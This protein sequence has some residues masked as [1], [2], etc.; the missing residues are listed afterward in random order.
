MRWAAVVTL[1]APTVLFAGGPAPTPTP[2][3]RPFRVQTMTP[4]PTAPTPTPTTEPTDARELEEQA[5]ILLEIH[6]KL[7]R[8]G[9]EIEKLPTKR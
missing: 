4:V 3:L 5:R 8:L 9:A 7:G 2:D 1:V 6:E